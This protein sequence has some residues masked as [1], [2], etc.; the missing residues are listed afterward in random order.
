M[1]AGAGARSGAPAAFVGK[2]GVIDRQEGGACGAIFSFS[3]RG[4]SWC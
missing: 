2:M 1:S 3:E 4:R